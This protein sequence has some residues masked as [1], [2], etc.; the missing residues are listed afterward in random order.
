MV[1][2]KTLVGIRENTKSDVFRVRDV[3]TL[4]DYY[5]FMTSHS[6]FMRNAL[7]I[8]SFGEQRLLD[9]RTPKYV[10]LSGPDELQM[11]KNVSARQAIELMKKNAKE[12]TTDLP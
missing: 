1:N 9:V 3:E 4:K 6:Y 12:H 2:P 7:S 5:C 11:L 8:G 10:L